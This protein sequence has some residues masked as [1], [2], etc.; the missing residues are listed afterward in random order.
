MTD[1]KGAIRDIAQIS[2][3]QRRFGI[4]QT[5]LDR[6]ARTAAMEMPL[7]GLHNPHTGES[8]MAPLAVLVDAICGTVN[9]IPFEGEFWTVS[10]E[11]SVDVSP[12]FDFSAV[13]LVS[14]TASL[15]GVGES[16]ALSHCQVRAGSTIVG[17]GSVRSFAAPAGSLPQR[18]VG[19]AEAN[20]GG[21]AGRLSELMSMAVSSTCDG[22]AVLHQAW[23]PLLNNAIGMVHGGVAAAGLELAGTAALNN[24]QTAPFHTSSM[25]VNFIR[26]LSAEN[27][28]GICTYEASVVHRGRRSA[29][30]DAVARGAGGTTAIIGRLTAYR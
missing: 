7:S 22:A 23:N 30:V 21:R 28:A 5:S 13:E 2:T 3:V 4:R 16:T 11:L 8:S 15:M 26:P 24:G 25:A 29:V 9:H 12:D 1:A 27:Q 14:A 17:E 18:P 20:P 10:T 6:R 19:A